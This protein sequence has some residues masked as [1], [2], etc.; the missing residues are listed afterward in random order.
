[1]NHDSEPLTNR[2]SSGRQGVAS[3][4]NGLDARRSDTTLAVSARRISKP[5]GGTT[6]LM[7]VD[8]DIAKGEFFGLIGPDGV[9]KSTLLKAIAGVLRVGGDFSVFGIET[10]S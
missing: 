1:M 2:P 9:G 8:L 3:H 6:A 7:S 5:F 10:A 4:Q